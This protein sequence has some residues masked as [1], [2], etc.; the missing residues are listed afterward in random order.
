MN[1]QSIDQSQIVTF[2]TG[3][4]KFSGAQINELESSQYTLCVL[5]VDSSMSISNFSHKISKAVKEVVRSLKNSKCSDNL[6]LRVLNF[7][8]G[9]NEV[10]GFTEWNKCD[11]T[12]YDNIFKNLG[13]NTSLFDATVDGL[14]SLNTYGKELVDQ[15]Y[16]PVN[17]I[18]IVITDGL[19]NFS[20]YTVKDVA[21][22]MKEGVGETK[23]ESLLSILIGVN[24]NDPQVGI[25]LK[26]FE[27][28]GG[29]DQYIEL[30]NVTEDSIAKLANFISKSVSAQSSSLGGGSK[31]QTIAF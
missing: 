7:D 1:S 28:V 24:I 27:T 20:T 21:R 6:M 12:Q 25:E 18:L 16:S 22:K 8:R 13:G 15:D 14:D 11:L 2:N 29:F 26:N 17:A 5:C 19:D 4:T 31:S 3:T 30:D 10:H 9:T 23:L